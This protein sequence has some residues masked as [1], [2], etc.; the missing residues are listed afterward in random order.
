MYILKTTQ[1]LQKQYEFFFLFKRES[2]LPPSDKQVSSL[3]TLG[4]SIRI[5]FLSQMLEVDVSK[6][7]LETRYRSQMK[8]CIFHK[9]L[10]PPS[11]FNFHYRM[12]TSTSPDSRI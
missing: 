5:P 12:A 8:P 2:T 10:S 3:V 9:Q 11:K 6:M 7:Y 4:Q 1:F